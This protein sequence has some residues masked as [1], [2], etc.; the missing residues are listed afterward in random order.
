MRGGRPALV[1]V[2]AALACMGAP[3][4]AQETKST[5]AATPAAPPAVLEPKAMELLKA[6]SDRLAQARAMSFTAT[7]SYESPS[8]LGPAL[9]YSTRS[10]VLM[11]RPDKLRVVTPG[12]G[13]ATEFYYD[14]KTMTAY[15]RAENLVAT[16]A[17]PP[18]TD[19]ALA[20]A[21]A[22]HSE[23]PE[24]PIVASG[25][26]VHGG[27]PEIDTG[28]SQTPASFVFDPILAGS[29]GLIG[30]ETAILT[31]TAVTIIVARRRAVRA[32]ILLLR[33]RSETAAILLRRRSAPILTGVIAAATTPENVEGVAL[34]AIVAVLDSD[35]RGSAIARIA[36]Q[37]LAAPAI[38]AGKAKFARIGGHG[39]IAF[40]AAPLGRLT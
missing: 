8:A 36:N 27:A 16:A 28:S 14:G 26:I 25:V 30:G 39:R 35:H 10:E 31:I 6:A 7:V 11:Q 17:A 29:N 3:L 2:L 23:V 15:A 13:P 19:A 38:D 5:A 18:T 21:A 20:A 40:K 32:A 34:R 9:V 33:R 37:L 1:L 22:R 4:C 24:H 12:D